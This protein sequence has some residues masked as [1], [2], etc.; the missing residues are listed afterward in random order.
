MT[1]IVRNGC[2]LEIYCGE[3]LVK[4]IPI[5]GM[6]FYQINSTAFGLSGTTGSY[7]DDIF[8]IDNYATLDSLFEDLQT[9]S[10]E[11][12]SVDVDPVFEYVGVTTTVYCRISDS[13]KV[14]IRTCKL[15][16]GDLEITDTDSGAVLTDALLASDYNADCGEKIVDLDE[17]IVI[18]P[19]GGSDEIV[20]PPMGYDAVSIFNC[21]PCPVL[22]TITLDVDG[23][24]TTNN[25]QLEAGETRT[26]DWS[27]DAITDFSVGE[28][29]PFASTTDSD[30]LSTQAATQ[31]LKIRVTYFNS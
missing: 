17:T 12:N 23:V 15:E 14:I 31:D 9:W 1:S 20:T 27:C 24:I 25:V 6:T 5:V 3:K 13:K 4:S 7:S 26:F 11:C 28:L 29:A 2:S 16:N 22:A 30:G 19:L 18:I 21:S 10:E 8:N